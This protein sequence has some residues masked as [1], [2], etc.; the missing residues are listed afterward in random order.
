MAHQ[1]VDE[2]LVLAHLAGAAAIGDPGRLD[3]GAVV[4]HVVDHPDESVVEHR[5][6]GIEDLLQFR[7]GGAPG[8]GRH[9]PELG[10][11]PLLFLLAG[12]DRSTHP[13]QFADKTLIFQ[14]SGN[15]L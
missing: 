3:D 4:A 12:H 14:M 1:I 6:R 10:D 7:H 13:F 5:Q 15:R 2:A 11:F 9:G 8:G